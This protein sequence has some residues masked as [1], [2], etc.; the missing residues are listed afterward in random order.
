MHISWISVLHMQIQKYK[1]YQAG[2]VVPLY[3]IFAWPS[4]NTEMMALVSSQEKSHCG[5]EYLNL[6][7]MMIYK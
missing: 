6:V 1:T 3:N 5:K 4:E 2:Q 7:G